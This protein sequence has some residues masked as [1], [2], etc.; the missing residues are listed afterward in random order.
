MDGAP[1]ERTSFAPEKPERIATNAIEGKRK[2]SKINEADRYSAAHNG[3]VA[4]SSPA[5]PT[6]DISELSDSHF[7]GVGSP[8]RKRL[9]PLLVAIPQ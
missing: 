1:L 2:L 8:H 3:L 4:D 7:V 9:A 5:G 6:K